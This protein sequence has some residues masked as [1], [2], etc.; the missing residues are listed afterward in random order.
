MSREI[1]QQALDAIL[2]A[3][4]SELLHPKP[5]ENRY[6]DIIGKLESALAQSEQESVAHLWECIGRWSSY[7]ALNG[8]KA[9]LAPPT[10]LVDA[11][12]AATAQ[13]EQEPDAWRNAAIRLGEDLH[14]VGPNGYY[15]MTAKQWLDWALSVV[16][17]AHPE[18]EHIE[19]GYDET[20]G[21]CTNNPCCE[22]AQPE[23]EPV[24]K[25]VCN[26][27][28]N[29]ETSFYEVD[30]CT[31]PINEV[32]PVYTAPPKREWVGLTDDEIDTYAQQH[33]FSLDKAPEWFTEVCRDIE[34]KLKEKN[35]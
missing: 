34:A 32:F 27:W 10:W 35:A 5:F 7:L 2:A 12:K 13:P 11:V 20:V 25:H 18:Q 14:S 21:M 28:I 1:M 33:S 29:P 26:L 16:N 6:L 22:Q 23:Q 30:R 19:C 15:D 31:H 3:R 17:I 24:A 4:E 8:E 9:N